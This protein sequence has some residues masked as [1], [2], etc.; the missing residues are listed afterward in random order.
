MVWVSPFGNLR[1][2]A[3]SQ[4]PT[5]YRS[6][7]RPSSPLCA[8]ASTKCSYRHL[9]GPYMKVE[10]GQTDQ[11]FS[12]VQKVQYNPKEII[13]YYLIIEIF[14]NNF[15]QINIKLNSRFLLKFWW[16]MLDLNQRPHPYQGCALPSELIAHRG[17]IPP[18]TMRMEESCGQ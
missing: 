1:I 8:K 17:V 9:I 6:V 13:K 10:N 4:L 12:F 5:A 18:I 11:N 7:S 3:Y 15:K 16:A 2:K 14:T